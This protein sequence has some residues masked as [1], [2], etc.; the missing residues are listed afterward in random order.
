MDII[1]CAYRDDAVSVEGH[2][3]TEQADTLLDK[4]EVEFGKGMTI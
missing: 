2:T 4:V 1:Q 3:V